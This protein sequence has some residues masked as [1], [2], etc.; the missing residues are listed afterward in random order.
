MRYTLSDAIHKLN[1]GAEFVISGD[2]L[3]GL[4]FIKPKDAK[5]PTQSEVDNALAQLQADHESLLAEKEAAKASAL[6]KLE[7]LGLTADE[8]SAI[9]G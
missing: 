1:P 3:E 9:V 6:A 7:T 4:T 2:S 5:V 8:I